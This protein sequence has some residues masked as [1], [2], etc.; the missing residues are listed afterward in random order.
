MSARQ[1][2]IPALDGV[3][4]LAIALVMLRHLSLLSW[5]RTSPSSADRVVAGV[6]GA[7]WIG[8]DLFFVLSGFLITGILLNERDR[9]APVIAKFG[10][11]YWR[12]V[13]RIVP[14]Y[15]TACAF[16]FFVLPILPYFR[17]QPEIA[18]LHRSA[19]W[20]WTYTV[21]I[22]EVLH[23]G[24]ATPFNTGHF[25]SLAVEEQFYLVWPFVVL[26]VSRK[27]L[28]RIVTVLLVAGPLVRLAC[29][30]F[31]APAAGATAAY[32]LSISRVD[33]LGVG[34]LVAL[35]YQ[36]D[37]EKWAHVHAFSG[38]VGAGAVAV[39]IAVALSG[40]D[41]SHGRLM[42][43]VGYSVVALG[44]GALIASTLDARGETPWIARLFSGRSLR[45]LGKYS[46]CLYIVHYPLTTVLDLLWTRV[47]IPSLWGSRL[48]SWAAYGSV[49]IAASFVIAWTSWRVLESPLLS[50]KDRFTFGIPA[51]SPPLAQDASSAVASELRGP[52]L[53]EP[54]AATNVL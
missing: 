48:P 14:L 11:F 45:A 29:L 43:T 33:V 30:H 25:W 54:D 20:Y 4:G 17:V 18:A 36:G 47:R 9:P 3:R 10:K 12:R 51:P 53:A 39:F 7:G 37:R 23:G 42:Q 6:T 26:A 24:A 52:H 44:M 27:T 46:Y 19:M 8:V 50:L 2:H 35:M 31:L 15:Y 13:L 32:T 34:A 38:W 5:F 21:N 49:L 22:L 40:S 28:L 41:G 1:S 16:L